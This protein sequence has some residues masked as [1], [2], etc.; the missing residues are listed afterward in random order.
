[1][2]TGQSH[3]W[4]AAWEAATRPDRTRATAVVGTTKSPT[5]QKGAKPSQPL[6][7]PA[8]R[9]RHQQHEQT[10]TSSLDDHL[11]TELELDELIKQETELQQDRRSYKDSLSIDGKCACRQDEQPSPCNSHA[12]TSDDDCSRS[13]DQCP[14]QQYT[15][16]YNEE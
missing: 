4:E 2:I 15:E 11:Q 3:E 10:A 1:M 5:M 7:T 6:R 16:W 13:A 8:R 14:D 9:H 12:S